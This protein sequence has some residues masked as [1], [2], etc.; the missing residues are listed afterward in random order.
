MWAGLELLPVQ[1][2]QQQESGVI[3][4]KEFKLVKVDNLWPDGVAISVVGKKIGILEFCRP[5]DSFPEQLQAAHDHKNLKYAIVEKALR[6][7]STAG[8]QVKVLPWV[9]GIRGL[10]IED[11]IHLALE[12][13]AIQRKDWAAAVSRTVV[14]SVESLAFMHRV[15]FS[16][17]GQNKVFD[18]DDPRT[19]SMKAGSSCCCVKRKLLVDEPSQLQETRAKWKRMA[20]NFGRRK[21]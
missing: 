16:S 21:H 13:L 1:S 12:F 20:T 18:T 4:D 9:V 2:E 17:N 8:W 7:Y 14:A 5:S 15:R 3:L 6:Q 10:V 19:V 11:G